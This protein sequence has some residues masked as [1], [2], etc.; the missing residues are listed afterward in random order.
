MPIIIVTAWYPYK[1]RMEVG[2]KAIEAVNKFPPDESTAKALG[3]AVLRD[4]HGIKVITMSEVMQ[5]K[6][7]EA[8]DRANQTIDFYME[9]DGFN[10]RIDIAATGIEAME[11]INMKLPE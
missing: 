11:S 10:F 5:G 9:V 8:L 1:R 2:K 7:Q 6:L 4:K 3:T